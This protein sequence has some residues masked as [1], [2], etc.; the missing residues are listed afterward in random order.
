VF[1]DD[2]RADRQFLLVVNLTKQLGKGFSCGP[3]FQ[4]LDNKSNDDSSAYASESY[5]LFVR[6]RF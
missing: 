2:V 3:E 5:S 6:Y 4:Y 1:T